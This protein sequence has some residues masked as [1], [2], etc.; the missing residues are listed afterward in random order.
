VE[1]AGDALA[2][3]GL[4]VDP[5]ERAT[6]GLQAADAKYYFFSLPVGYTGNTTSRG[7]IGI[8]ID[9]YGSSDV[10]VEMFQ[11]PAEGTGSFGVWYSQE[12]SVTQCALTP[13]DIAGGNIA[14]APRYPAQEEG[15]TPPGARI[16][17]LAPK[18]SCAACNSIIQI[19]QS[20][21]AAYGATAVCAPLLP[22]ALLPGLLCEYFVSVYF[23]A[24]AKTLEAWADADPGLICTPM[25]RLCGSIASDFVC[26]TNRDC[27]VP[28]PTSGESVACYE[29]QVG[30]GCANDLISSAASTIL[31]GALP[32]KVDNNLCGAVVGEAIAG[33]MSGTP[34]SCDN[35]CNKQCTAR[36][37]GTPDSPEGDASTCISGGAADLENPVGAYVFEFI[38]SDSATISGGGGYQADYDL[39]V[40]ADLQSNFAGLESYTVRSAALRVDVAYS[41]TPLCTD[42]NTGQTVKCDYPLAECITGTFVTDDFDLTGALL[43]HEAPGAASNPLPDDF[44]EIKFALAGAKSF[45]TARGTILQ[46]A[47]GEELFLG[48][49][50]DS[51]DH[52][53]GYFHSNLVLPAPYV[54]LGISPGEPIQGQASI[55]GRD[56]GVG[57]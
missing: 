30:C 7:G 55:T 24:A 41:S 44:Y 48:T 28:P 21:G 56:A 49:A 8:K 26:P 37:G 54:Q 38:G 27:S 36:D 29:C 2:N 11:Q 5:T 31:C 40:G 39:L 14:Y 1:V 47:S 23:G 52:E 43:I 19:A 50:S 16:A 33:A 35:V 3:A 12:T 9:G 13:Q 10:Y 46:Y 57:P 42:S 25:L 34:Q 51:E 17:R 32:I 22:E 4:V 18:N 20:Y 53:A 6:G 15:T 45:P